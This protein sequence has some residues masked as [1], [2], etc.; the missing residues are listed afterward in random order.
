MSNFAQWSIII[1]VLHL[2]S[3]H[4]L[5][6]AVIRGF[7]CLV[8]HRDLPDLNGIVRLYGNGRMSIFA[9]PFLAG[10]TE[11]EGA[12]EH[13]LERLNDEGLGHAL[14]FYL[15]SRLPTK[16]CPIPRIF[17]PDDDCRPSWYRQALCDRPQAVADAFVVVHRVRVRAKEPPDQHLHDLTM[18][19]EYAEVA[20]LAVPW[21]FTPFPSR[22]SAIQLETLRQVL[23]AALRHMCS[24][25]LSELVQRRLARKGM[26]IGQRAQ[27]LATGALVLPEEWLPKLVGFLSDE[28]ATRSAP[29]GA[30]SALPGGLPGVRQGVLFQPGVVH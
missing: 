22:R 6:K 7:R 24:A 1:L 16:R 2:D 20:H 19:D 14:G 9:S 25:A 27:W 26:D 13:L 5:V 15:L 12:G 17:T 30:K 11:D 18:S 8:V 3:D 23:W 21:M 10:L 28:E 4:E 29:F